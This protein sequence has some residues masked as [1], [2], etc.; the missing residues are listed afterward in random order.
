[1]AFIYPRS[2]IGILGGGLGAWQLVNAAHRLGFLVNALVTNPKDMVVSVADRV[3]YGELNDASALRQIGRSSQV[4]VYHD[5]TPDLTALQEAQ[6]MPLLVQGTDLLTLI[7]DRYF[8][9]TFLGDLNINIAPYMMVMSID[10]VRQA[11]DRIGFPCVIKPI[12]KGLGMAKKR[13][14]HSAADIEQVPQFLHG[15][16]YIV[17][18]W[19]E[20]KRELMVLASKDNAG[21]VQV[22]PTLA[23]AY[24]D[25]QLAHVVANPEQ[26]GEVEEEIKR[27]VRQ[28][29]AAIRYQGTFSVSFF[30]TPSGV[31][32]VRHIA[33]PLTSAGNLYQGATGFSQYELLLRNVCQWPVPNAYLKK[34][35]ALY[36]LRHELEPQIFA[37]VQKKATWHFKFWPFKNLDHVPIQIGEALVTAPTYPELLELVEGS[38]LWQLD[39]KELTQHD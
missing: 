1:M 3:F 8:E 9:K 28:L 26:N 39:Q 12:Q 10:D 7:Q 27:V 23:M 33:G 32:Y 29:A 30:E 15:G 2:I 34:A 31:L 14:L 37:E 24:R 11:T 21:Q 13:I 16:A 5:T 19:I 35:A 25:G 36:T 18:S 6:V 38:S 22:F 20:H 17:E 4:L